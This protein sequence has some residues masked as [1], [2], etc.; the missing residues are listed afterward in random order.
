MQLKAHRACSLVARSWPPD[1]RDTRPIGRGSCAILWRATPLAPDRSFASRDVRCH[2][3]GSS[4]QAAARLPEHRSLR[5]NRLIIRKQQAATSKTK[6]SQPVGD[7]R[8][9]YKTTKRLMAKAKRSRWSPTMHN[10]SSGGFSA[11]EKP[12]S[13]RSKPLPA[14]PWQGN[15]LWVARLALHAIA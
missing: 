8:L 5:K 2:R 6:S 10:P 4:A 1:L 3:V 12:P 11:Y 9:E 13:V 15:R 7:L 14:E